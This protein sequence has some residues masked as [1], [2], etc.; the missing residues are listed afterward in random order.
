[1]EYV[2]ESGV[3]KYD[4]VLGLTGELTRSVSDHYPVWTRLDMSTLGIGD[5]M[6]ITP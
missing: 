5:D 2:L 6:E 3:Y 1:M 4:Q